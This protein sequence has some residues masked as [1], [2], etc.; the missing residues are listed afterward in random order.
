MKPYV[1]RLA[2]RWW[3]AAAIATSAC[4]G[5]FDAEEVLPPT[6]TPPVIPPLPNPGT[7]AAAFQGLKRLTPDLDSLLIEWD[8]LLDSSVTPP[9]PDDAYAYAVFATFDGSL[10]DFAQPPLEQTAP[11]AGST[12]LTGLALGTRVRVAIRAIPLVDLTV[13]PDGNEVVL[14]AEILS[15][16]FV[17]VSAPPG[18][19]GSAPDR[20]FQHINDAVVAAL[21][22]G[23]GANIL[24][25][26]GDYVEEVAL[27]GAMHLYGGYPSGFAGPRDGGLHP[28]TIRPASGASVGIRVF[29]NPA[30]T[31]VDGVDLAGGGTVRLGIDLRDAD[32]ELSNSAILSFAGEGLAVH[33]RLRT[34]RFLL[35]RVAVAGG[36][37]EGIE[38]TG[39]VDAFF[40]L[41]SFV[42]NAHEGI[43]F[44]DLSVQPAEL[45]TFRL[46]RCTLAGNGQDGL[47]VELDELDP[48]SGTSSENGEIEVAIEECVVEGNGAVGLSLDIDYDANDEVEARAFL[49]DNSVVANLGHGIVLDGDEPGLYVLT[50]NGTSA[51]RGGGLLAGSDSIDL[52]RATFI[53]ANHWDRGSGAEGIKVLGPADVV[54][55][56]V[57]VTASRAAALAG[58]GT[59]RFVNGALWGA[60]PPVD[61]T[62]EFSYREDGGGGIG[63]FTG[64]VELG[65]FPAPAFFLASAGGVDQ[66]PV[67]PEVSVA[68]GDVLELDDDG[69][70]RAVTEAAG[71]LARFD[72]P[73]AV[74]AAIDTFVGVFD[75]PDVTESPVLVLGSTWV[76]RGDPTERDLDDSVTDVGVLGG[77]LGAFRASRAGG[78]VPLVV[79]ELDPAMGPA[80]TAPADVRVR[81]TRPLDPASVDATTFAVT[82]DGVPVAGQRVVQ[83]HDL[84]FTP[85]VPFGSGELEI[86]LGAGLAADAAHGGM[87]LA[88]PFRYTVSLP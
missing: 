14:S 19:D 10:P 42:S 87:K 50:G 73:L 38:A 34:T 84:V 78:V 40:T 54:L 43:E 8:P 65:R 36:G 58:N 85:T 9:V 3:I 57:A 51:N 7:G 29:T 45:S 4:G 86:T 1:R 37:V 53:L 56:H 62:T 74:P 82:L 28:S 33:D 60:P 48:L 5:R 39:S 13:P 16:L 17:D 83:G 2:N 47:D 20:A 30:L 71:G 15:R 81:F 75:S 67:P 12:A 25:A 24:V 35:H 41:S 70:A 79:K 80:L 59:A 76:D 64:P 44:D 11:G 18:G 26:E 23:T 69:V 52:G 32:L 6:V 63:C 72:P 55:S 49:R 68:V 21:G 77:R 88:L 46:W 66:V 22:S 61:A 31:L 27:L